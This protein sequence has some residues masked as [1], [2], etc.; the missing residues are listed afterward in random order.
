MPPSEKIKLIDKD[1]QILSVRE[2]CALLQLNRSNL[3]YQKK[4]ILS[5]VDILTM[6]KIDEIFTKRPYYGVPRITKELNKDIFVA[7]HKRVY[8]LMGIMGIEAVFPKKNLSKPNIA[9]DIYPYLLTD[10]AVSHP[11]HV[12]GVDI[13]YVRLRGDWLYLFVVLDWFSRYIL[14]W[15]LSDSLSSDFCCETLRHALTIAIPDIHNS[16][17]GSQLTAEEYVG[18]LKSHPNI[19]ISMDH[20][21]RCFDNIFT[22]R[23]WRTIKYEEVYLKDYQNPREARQSLT[24][25]LKFYNEER[26]HSSL[27]YKTPAEIYFKKSVKSF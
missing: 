12:W 17:Q 25:Y 23:L 9:H 18:I 11:N 10:L 27:N 19:K 5:D 4:P 8:R 1:N 22:E 6:N 14:S 16:D 26:F 20:K 24:E 13:T 21:G 2:Q 7:N 15:E 3:Y